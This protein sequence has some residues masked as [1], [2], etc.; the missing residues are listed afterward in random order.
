MKGKSLPVATGAHEL[1]MP[2]SLDRSIQKAMFRTSKKHN[3]RKYVLLMC[4]LLFLGVLH[5]VF[6][7][8]TPL[9]SVNAMATLVF[10]FTIGTFMFLLVAYQLASIL[11][12]YFAPTNVQVGANGVR[13]HWLLPVIGFVSSPWASWQ[14]IR[15]VQLSESTLIPGTIDIGNMYTRETLAPT[16]QVK[17]DLR[18]THFF[19]AYWCVL[20]N[21]P[22]SVLRN[23]GGLPIYTTALVHEGDVPALMAAM[24]FFANE[25]CSRQIVDWRAQSEQPSF[26]KLWIEGLNSNRLSE[27]GLTE[28]QPGEKL[29]DGE[30]RILSRIGAG[31]Q[32]VTYRAE[33]TVPDRAV[34]T[35]A[36]KE[37]FLP[38]RGG[39]Q[40]TKRA[41][42]NV[43][44]EAVLLRSLSH[45]QIVRFIDTFASGSRA[46]LAMEL[47]EGR[48]LRHLVQECGAL[49]ESQCI[50]LARQLCNILEYLHS[51]EPPIAHRDFTPDNLLL[52]DDQTIVLID[53]NVA[54]RLESECSHAVA[55]K[56][57]Y[58]SPEQFRGNAT[59]KSDIYSLG[60]VLFWLLTGRDPEPISVSHPRS[61]NLNVGILD[62]IVAKATALDSS[63]RYK[64]ATEIREDLS[65]L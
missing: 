64:N 48:T 44:H 20:A 45:P 4:L 3:Y 38:V 59:I 60:G 19:W 52:R 29:L 22:I 63:E 7:L 43:E 36:L 21:L 8:M 27:D 53:F 34:E 24:T 37:F 10:Y 58:I 61:V 23:R 25:K 46:Y 65:N 13:L 15:S 49:E 16:L 5:F 39:A 32:A 35:V 47:I 56:Q 40:I 41:I 51:Q 6:A 9:L 30:Y 62:G 2:Y 57:C 28:L 17:L 42:R 14:S 54:E 11:P 50:S 55:G 18:K 1:L 26:T 12:Q 33:R 31:G